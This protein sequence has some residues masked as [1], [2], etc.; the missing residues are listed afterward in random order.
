MSIFHLHFPSV[1]FLPEGGPGPSGGRQLDT[2]CQ[3]CQRLHLGLPLL[4]RDGDH[5]WLRPPRHHRPVSSRNHAAAAAGHTGLNGQCLHG[6]LQGQTPLRTT[7]DPCRD[8]SDSG[9]SAGVSTA[10]PLTH[11][12]RH[13]N[14]AKLPCPPGHL[15]SGTP[16]L[17]D[18]CHPEHL[19][20]GTTVLSENSRTAQQDVH[21]DTQH[22][23]FYVSLCPTC[24]PCLLSRLDAC[25]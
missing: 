7:S 9:R 25:L 6:E 3:Q 15:S 11:Q 20:S 2:V 18:T 19:S 4:H 13:K 8:P 21:S 16:A 24:L 22:V 12:F 1:L 10:E 23:F 14:K 17:R 5:Y